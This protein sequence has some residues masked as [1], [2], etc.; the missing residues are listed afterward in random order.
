MVD[1]QDW[2]GRTETAEDVL[3]ARLVHEFNATFDRPMDAALLGI[4]WCLAPPVAPAAA[5]GPD[6]HAARGGF[7]PPV[8]LPRRMWAGGALT[9]H[10]ALQVDDPI[11][12]H[13]RI[14]GVAMKRG[15][16]GALCFVTVDHEIRT[17]RGL[18]VT[19]RQDIVYREAATGPAEAP[20]AFSGTAPQWRQEMRAGPV[21]LFRYSALT[22]NGHRIHY[23]RNY[24]VAVEHYAGLVVHGPLQATLLLNFAA[25]CA[26]ERPRSFTFRG[27]SPLIDSE[28]FSLNARSTD[29]GLEL[30]AETDTGRRTM[31]AQAEFGT[32][33]KTFRTGLV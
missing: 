21:L 14:A 17:P 6:G 9:F 8:A 22:F 16:T 30:W 12:R 2:V 3:T 24:A 32:S 1:L 27:V 7:L 11:T 28:N 19:E 15:R 5:L 29:A 10:D 25:Q 31:Q 18:G 20:A 4:H 26:G 23:D 33:A 13:S